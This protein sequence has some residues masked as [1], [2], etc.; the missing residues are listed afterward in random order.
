MRM[1]SHEMAQVELEWT[2][3]KQLSSY[4][5]KF[6]WKTSAMRKVEIVEK[7]S[8]A[9]KE[10]KVS[11]KYE[12]EIRRRNT[13]KKYEEEIQSCVAGAAYCVWRDREGYLCSAHGGR[14]GLAA[15]W[16]VAQWHGR[17]RFHEV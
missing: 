16:K 7:Q 10:R 9:K 1:K 14:R 17:A 6:S 12:E 13:K 3:R 11:K 2:H 5:R 15:V 4:Q 8:R